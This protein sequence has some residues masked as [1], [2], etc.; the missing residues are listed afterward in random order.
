MHCCGWIA[1]IDILII[2]SARL[3]AQDVGA[4]GTLPPLRVTGSLGATMAA[5]TISGI[6]RRLA[7]FS[8]IATCNATAE[9]YGVS[10]PFSFTIS[11]RERSFQQPFNAFGLSP[12][13]RWVTLHLGSRSM[14]WSPYT[15][16]GVRFEGVGVEAAPK[17]FHIA[18]FYGRLQR[19]VEQDTTNRLAV[20][21]WRRAGGGV[22]LRFGNEHGNI[23]TSFFMAG[24]DTTSLRV[25]PRDVAPMQNAALG[26]GLLFEV[27]DGITLDLD[28][29]GSLL[30]RNRFSFGLEEGGLAGKVT[31]R[32]ILK[33]K[34]YF[35]VRTSSTLAFAG[36]A[37]LAARIP[38]GSL[39]LQ[40]L[41][42][43]PDYSSLGAWAYE[44]DVL[45]LTLAPSV[46]TRDGT[47]RG[48]ASIG[49]QQDNVDDEKAFTTT[50]WIG[51]LSAG[52]DPRPEFGLGMQYAN[53]STGQTG[54]RMPLNDSIRVRS[55]NHSAGLQA[56]SMLGAGPLR[57]V[58]VGSLSVMRY[59]DHNAYTRA[60][61]DN[62]AVIVLAT[63][64]LARTDAP[65]SG[66]LQSGTASFSIARTHSAAGVQLVYG[67]S[68]GTSTTFFDGLLQATLVLGL[69][70]IDGG[71]AGT[72]TVFT[73]SL[74]LAMAPSRDD[75]ISLAVQ[76]CQ[77][78]GG[79]RA[80]SAFSE[81]TST[82][83]YNRSFRWKP[84]DTA[85]THGAP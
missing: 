80:V 40:F 19:A 49:M 27:L 50:R 14:S 53:Y 16:A 8:W 34:E 6:D 61:T 51:S 22:A 81:F 28:A 43:E 66:R 2:G 75:R 84:F 5:N 71:S 65:R 56:R 85:A 17:D 82:L 39:A 74:S 12:H 42:I 79:S 70:R 25:R 78:Q 15:Y 52:W 32:R 18:A 21:A 44:T 77:N 68:V 69:S 4:L 48:G 1:M 46:A 36:R 31:T 59:V 37:S 24:D 33:L 26:V 35:D 57:H 9:T 60:V 64:A 58:L 7:P 13:Y 3:S 45:A 54:A 20:P 29:G 55:V 73:Q 62:D 72:S 11:E 83:T 76:G 47:L 41:M 38:F 30:T 63:Y 23:R 10:I 67:G